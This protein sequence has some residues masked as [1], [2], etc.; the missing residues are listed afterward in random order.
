MM[1]M[2]VDSVHKIV[3]DEGTVMSSH[4]LEA[5]LYR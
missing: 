4:L 5:F 3:Y 2:L 1:I